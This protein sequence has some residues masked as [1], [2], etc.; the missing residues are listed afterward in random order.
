MK[1]AAF[2]SY[3][4]LLAYLSLAPSSGDGMPLWDKAM[5]A[6][7]YA[8]YTVLGVWLCQTRA[9]IAW[10]LGYVFCFGIAMEFGQ[11]LVPGRDTSVMDQVANAVG[12]VIGGWL[13]VRLH[14]PVARTTPATEIT[15]D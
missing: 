1:L 6:P 15:G 12:I 8:S 9:Q 3:T 7:T 13:A 2:I 4:C 11:S 14:K 5:H 10:L